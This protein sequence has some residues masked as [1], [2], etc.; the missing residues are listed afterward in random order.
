MIKS[1]LKE[2]MEKL[3]VTY[4]ELEEKTGISS[5]TITRARGDMISECRLSTLEIIAKALKVNTKDLYEEEKRKIE[6]T[7]F[8][9]P[10]NPMFSGN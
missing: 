4:K 2:I 3:D 6:I 5:Q 9:L 7:G 1:N 8:I 10:V